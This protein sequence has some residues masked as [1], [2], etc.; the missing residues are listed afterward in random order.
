MQNAMDVIRT[1]IAALFGAATM[2]TLCLALAIWGH[3]AWAHPAALHA[4]LG[5]GPVPID[6]ALAAT[7][8]LALACIYARWFDRLLAGPAIA[9]GFKFGAIAW[10]W[11]VSLALILREC[12]I[13]RWT[14]WHPVALP[15]VT[16]MALTISGA[17]QGLI[18]GA[19]RRYDE[20]RHGL[21]YGV[22]DRRSLG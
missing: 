15:L 8:T 12:G 10:T 18:Y 9:R 14:T 7:A 20:Y 1:V 17:V 5:C 2:V 21:A 4:H 3:V 19:G 16:L 6:A 11:A 22:P 13:T